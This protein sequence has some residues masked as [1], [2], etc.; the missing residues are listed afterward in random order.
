M[1]RLTPLELR[2]YLAR[3]QTRTVLVDVREVWEFDICRIDGARNLPLSQW[4]AGAATLDPADE[5]VLICHH[6]MRSLQAAH[7]LE[8]SGFERIINLEGGI[9]AW[10]REVNP[11]MARY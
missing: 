9:D 4:P 1:Q 3:A 6:G 5:T 8:Q 11:G 10:A 7:H 2:D